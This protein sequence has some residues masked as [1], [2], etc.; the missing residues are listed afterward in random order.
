M[1][2]TRYPD[3]PK[4][5]K[6]ENAFHEEWVIDS[7]DN[8]NR[9]IRLHHAPFFGT[10]D[11]TVGDGSYTLFPNKDFE[12]VFE[13][14]GLRDSVESPVF[15][16][17]QLVNPAL[18]G[19]FQIHGQMLGGS[20]YDPL[21]EILDYLIK[22]VNNPKT[23][24]YRNVNNI[25]ALFPPKLGYTGWSDLQN[26]QYLASAIDD[27]G[28]G[29]E[30]KNDAVI[31]ALNDVAKD[32][33]TLLAE[34]NAFDYPGHIAALNPHTVTTTQLNAHPL[35]LEVPDAILA[36]GMNLRQL[37]TYVRSRGVQ[38]TD[39]T[40]FLQKWMS[41]S[42]TGTTFT[43]AGADTIAVRSTN[44]DSVL[45]VD[46]NKVELVSKGSVVFSAG[47]DL[48]G[49]RYQQYVCGLNT[50][51]ITSGGAGLT[52]GGLTLNGVEILTSR[53][54]KRY[55]QDDPSGGGGAEIELAAQSTNILFTG[56]GTPD[57]PLK[58]SL[59]I[60][61]ATTAVDGGVQLLDRKGNEGNGYAATPA[62]GVEYDG[63]FNDYVPKT[64]Q[65]NNKPLSG[66]GISIGKEDFNLD[67]ADNTADANKPLST[68]QKTRTDALVA[69]DHKHT[70]A[71]LMIGSATVGDYGTVQ[72]AT[73]DAELA[74]GKAV[75]PKVL[76]GLSDRLEAVKPLLTGGL[77]KDAVDFTAIGVSSFNI[78]NNWTLSPAT[79]TQF[80]LSKSL[81]ASRG[82]VTG[83]VDLT[84]VSGAEWYKKNCAP[85]LAWPKA[86]KATGQSFNDMP[87]YNYGVFVT[88][89]AGAVAD[90][91]G[92]RI[93]KLRFKSN[94]G[95]MKLRFGGLTAIKQ[96]YLDGTA[97]ALGGNAV[98]M[99]PELEE[100]VHVV[101]V[102]L[103]NATGAGE[104]GI[105]FEVFEDDNITFKSEPGSC[106]I[107]VLTTYA[108]YTNTRFYIYANV[109]TGLYEARMAPLQTDGVDMNFIY[110]GYVDTGATAIT[111]NA[112]QKVVFEKSID[113]GLFREL[114]EH[115]DDLH[116][117]ETNDLI[118]KTVTGL[119][120]TK[121]YGVADTNLTR[122]MRYAAG[123][124]DAAS[125]PA[126]NL[127]SNGSGCWVDTDSLT[128]LKNLGLAVELN[129]QSPWRWISQSNPDEAG[130]QT[131]DGCVMIHSDA[132][133]SF[134]FWSPVENG[135][136]DSLRVTEWLTDTAQ[137]RTAL[138]LSEVK[139]NS[140]PQV[141]PVPGTETVAMTAGVDTTWTPDF[142][143]P[144]HYNGRNI[145][146]PGLY[147]FR[148]RY[149]PA[150]KELRYSVEYSR[151]DWGAADIKG[152]LFV[153]KFSADM[154]RFFKGQ[155]AVRSTGTARLRALGS[156]FDVSTPN[157]VL[158]RMNRYKALVNNYVLPSAIAEQRDNNNGI[159]AFKT[160]ISFWEGLATLY[161]AKGATLNRWTQGIIM[162]QE[163]AV[164]AH[165]TDYAVP[166]QLLDAAHFTMN[167]KK[168][169]EIP[170]WR[171]ATTY[172]AI[173]P[174]KTYTS[175]N[176]MHYLH[177]APINFK[178]T[179]VTINAI[180]GKGLNV[181]VDNMLVLSD[182]VGG[183]VERTATVNI[184]GSNIN[185]RG[186]IEIITPPVTDNSV[187]YVGCKI[188]LTGPNGE[189]YTVTTGAAGWVCIDSSEAVRISMQVPWHFTQRNWEHVIAQVAKEKD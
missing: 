33:R 115:M 167:G 157:A 18:S 183:E 162:T 91:S 156:L 171:P 174:G 78:V 118:L 181:R 135:K 17:I 79:A 58:G 104:I 185:F 161:T 75:M 101:G 54:V 6:P 9:V 94:G 85:E 73:T 16:G 110:V 164:I 182:D 168:V 100:G 143:L 179:S 30:D 55:Q 124:S 112:G 8:S 24:D 51:K 61:T 4:G 34:I 56:K 90:G 1:V 41:G 80:F 152:K 178:P 122:P 23:A 111:P 32:A 57:S 154:S 150:L 149:I 173:A 64:T 132:S 147:L 86:V 22:T 165:T 52:E 140:F 48:N 108:S 19:K 71:Q 50:L 83:S 130:L 70:W 117:H 131:I 186:L 3:D 123:S 146:N 128:N 89:Q 44:S 15:M 98:E 97:Y 95:A 141:V 59:Q 127:G 5:T 67:L 14:T 136:Y 114:K 35:N 103:N 31:A 144:S 11:I 138:G 177:R 45:K 46:T 76:K 92:D 153:F 88:H 184:A 109:Q 125:L 49:A 188:V 189:T 160:G 38:E 2:T 151:G 176:R 87:E 84:K 180:S 159:L 120:N 69:K 93:V 172:P 77:A 102:V 158:L 99:T 175:R 119:E 133:P 170:W 66:T 82:T 39:L 60:P 121:P 20:W 63:N 26:K 29:A 37:M 134:E 12:Y 13:L 25:P 65:V 40:Q 106:H 42:T 126:L 68:P 142:K 137:L 145:R 53:T 74:L 10:L 107:G 187:A 62:A 155:V 113:Y 21:I 43:T 166:S 105:L 139:S 72:L 47:Y 96:I 7:N 81:D 36:Y 163:S 148:Y 116:A 27:L 129:G 28:I 169:V